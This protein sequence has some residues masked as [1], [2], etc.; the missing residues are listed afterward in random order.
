MSDEI[1]S[2]IANKEDEITKIEEEAAKKEASAEGQ[3][4]SLYDPKIKEA[5]NKL[6]VEQEKYDDAAAKAADWLN[7]KKELGARVNSLKKDHSNTIKNKTKALKA[8][9]NEID[10]EKDSKINA[11]N[12]EIKAL[13]KQLKELEKEK[14][15]ASTQKN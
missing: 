12:K 7:K 9:L 11:I 8:K 2:N 13:E 5:E 4:E 6:K 15:A 1:L 10:Q 14:K 3:I